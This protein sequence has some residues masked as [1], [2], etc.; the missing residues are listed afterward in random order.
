[1]TSNQVDKIKKTIGRPR[2]NPREVEKT[3]EEILVHRNYHRE[4]YRNNLSH[5]VQCSLCGAKSSYQKIKRHQSTQKC[6]Y[7]QFVKASHKDEIDNIH[8]DIHQI[9]NK[10]N[11]YKLM[12]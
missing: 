3:E 12:V 11:E 1:M 2:I 9:I 8:N 6:L 5:P 10:I 4:Y 7:L